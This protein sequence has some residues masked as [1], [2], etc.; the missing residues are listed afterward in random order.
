MYWDDSQPRHAE[1]NQDIKFQDCRHLNWSGARRRRDCFVRRR[2]MS[3]GTWLY[4]NHHE[5]EVRRK[6]FPAC[7]TVWPY[8]RDAQT[9]YDTHGPRQFKTTSALG[10]D[11]EVGSLDH[12]NKRPQAPEQIRDPSRESTSARQSRLKDRNGCPFSHIRQQ[13]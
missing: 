11:S 4:D 1:P 5:W 7:L 12:R 2:K 6:A 9:Q 8:V 13:A 10:L 3:Q